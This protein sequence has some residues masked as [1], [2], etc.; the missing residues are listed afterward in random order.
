MPNPQEWLSLGFILVAV[1]FLTRAEKKR[2]AEGITVNA[3]DEPTPAPATA[4]ASRPAEA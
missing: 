2:V 3:A 1:Y 4:P